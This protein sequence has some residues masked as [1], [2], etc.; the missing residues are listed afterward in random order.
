MVQPAQVGGD[1]QAGSVNH[2]AGGKS[3]SIGNPPGDATGLARG[4]PPLILQAV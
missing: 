1:L 4:D 2:V 3:V